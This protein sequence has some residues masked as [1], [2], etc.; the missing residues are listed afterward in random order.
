[1]KT[2]LL[3]L[4]A[5]V[6]KLSLYSQTTISGIVTDNQGIPLPGANVYIANSYDGTSTNTK[7]QFEFYTTEQG[8]QILNVDFIGFEQASINVVLSGKSIIQ[9]IQLKEKFNEL[10]AVNITA[11]AFEASDRKKSIALTPIDMVTTPSASGDLYGAIQA[12]PG[13]TTV[14]E[15]GRLY[16]KGGDSRESKTFIDGTLVYVPYSSSTPNTSV[17][18]RF[19]PF[20]FGGTMFSTGAYS[21]EYGQ[22]LSGILALKTNEMPLEDQ[23]NI[24]V[25]SVGIGAAA[26]K[27][28]DKSSLTTSLNYN[29]LKPYMQL[30][31]QNKNWND[32]PLSVNGEISYRLKTEKSG[33]LK[34]YSSIGSTSMSLLQPNL[35]VL[36]NQSQY[37]L[38]NNNVFVNG[39]WT[40]ELH[41]KWIL[42]SGVS[43]TYNTDNVT[44]DTANYSKTLKGGHGKLMLSKKVTDKIKINMG[45]E[46]YS[47]NYNMDYSS[48]TNSVFIGFKSTMAT[49]FAEADIYASNKLATRVGARFEYSNYLNKFNVAPRISAAYKFSKESQ[50]SLAYGWFFQNPDDDNLLYTNDLNFER[51]DHYTF[52]FQY[53]KNK[54]IIRSELFYKDY[55]NL[56]KFTDQPFY[57]AQGYTNEGYGNV[58][59]FDVFY[60]DNKTIKKGEYWISYSYINAKKNY[61]DFPVLSSPNYTSKHNLTVVYKHWVGILRSQIGASYKYA[62]PRVYNNPNSKVFNNEHTIAY[63]TLDLN[64]SFLYRQNIIF[65]AS[66]SNIAGFKQH[67]GY[68]YS[69]TPNREGFFE[70]TA[71]LPSAKRFYLI[72]CFITLSRKG[73]L[74][75]MD[76]IN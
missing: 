4:L 9:N 69:D 1:M 36:D 35:N 11:S 45:S 14:G 76:K 61:L 5:F 64:W 13:S 41:N 23:L 50:V 31:P 29:N 71:I 37:N 17:R 32:E 60:R 10:E 66:I 67:F 8:A 62:S 56:V 51:A 73:D 2:R 75:Q 48:D 25:L 49:A 7:G 47:K 70:S 38:V 18:S 24:S 30:V 34:F 19:N 46:L 74:N 26:T 44:L 33:L 16:V 21:A 12:L 20:M 72:A 54:R 27:T 58:F 15:S 22:A 40:G 6:L 59:G 3:F 57:T 43:Y 28:F 53:E 63:Q 52:N 55:K 65:Y 68:S 39:S 42:T